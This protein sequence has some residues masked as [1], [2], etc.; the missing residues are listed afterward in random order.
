MASSC[1]RT[2]P[3]RVCCRQ[4]TRIGLHVVRIHQA[5]S[6]QALSTRDSRIYSVATELSCRIRLRW[7]TLALFYHQQRFMLRSCAC[8]RGTLR[9]STCAAMLQRRR[10]V[11]ACP[12]ALVYA[13]CRARHQQTCLR[14]LGAAARAT[15]IPPAS[16]TTRRRMHRRRP[17]RGGRAPLVPQWRCTKSGLP[18]L[19]M[20]A[21]M[22]GRARRPAPPRGRIRGARAFR[23]AAA[24]RTPIASFTMNCSSTRQC[25]NCTTITAIIRI[26]IVMVSRPCTILS[27]RPRSRR[28][29]L[30]GRRR[31]QR[32]CIVL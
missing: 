4:R 10:R 28:R 8:I 13:S 12:A 9:P 22:S 2:M 18:K 21:R 16:S 14:S 19:S 23:S 15:K 7:V 3:T 11:S 26:S 17:A 5:S 6:V 29:V 1:A 25:C 32:R 20:A 24:A 31:R 30:R 27:R